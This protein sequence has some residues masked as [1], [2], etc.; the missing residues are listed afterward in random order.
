MTRDAVE[1]RKT[2][3]EVLNEMRRSA[4]ILGTATRHME[5]DFRCSATGRWFTVALHRKTPT[6]AYRV[7]RVGTDY[8]ALHLARGS[9]VAAKLLDIDANEIDYSGIRCPYCT[10]GKWLVVKC[11]TC[12]RLSC[13]GGVRECG[14]KQLHMCP[15]CGHEGHIQG[16]I[17]KVTGKTVP[18]NRKTLSAGTRKLL[19]PVKHLALSRGLG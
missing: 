11:G 1:K 3:D 7:V 8:T 6:Q 17:E 16:T 12:R 14:G 4:G 2:Q 13:G 5:L 9:S 10:G 19:P 18:P 15:W